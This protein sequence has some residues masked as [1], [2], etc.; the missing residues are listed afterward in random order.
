MYG[1]YDVSRSLSELEVA[2]RKALVSSS[3][4][5]SLFWTI[6]DPALYDICAMLISEKISLMVQRQRKELLWWLFL[7]NIFA[8]HTLARERE[9]FVLNVL[10]CRETY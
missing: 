9:N 1:S 4:S 8:N 6:H 7:L 10:R 2:T 3:F 5:Y